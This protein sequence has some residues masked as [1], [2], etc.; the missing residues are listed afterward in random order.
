[1]ATL[2]AR[3]FGM[4]LVYSY[5]A[6]ALLAFI[7]SQFGLPTFKVGYGF[8]IIIVS[9]IISMMASGI[10]D[11][12]VDKTE[13]LFFILVVGALIGSFFLLKNYLPEMFSF[14]PESTKQAFSFIS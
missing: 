5:L 11:F 4:V 12:K 13:V 10:R 8:L 6:V 3:S 1:M 14:V 2:N 7:A 9:V